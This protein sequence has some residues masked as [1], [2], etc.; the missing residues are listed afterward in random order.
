MLVEMIKVMCFLTYFNMRTI[1]KDSI[2]YFVINCKS[3]KKVNHYL[4][5]SYVLINKTVREYLQKY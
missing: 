5:Y 3:L 2:I 1:F 4:L